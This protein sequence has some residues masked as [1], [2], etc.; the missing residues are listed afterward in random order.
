M[1]K[2]PAAKADKDEK[3]GEELTE[4]R[5]KQLEQETQEKTEQLNACI[6]VAIQM[7]NKQSFAM[8]KCK[9]DLEK[10]PLDGF[11][12]KAKK[13]ETQ[14]GEL[15]ET[16]GKLNTVDGGTQEYQLGA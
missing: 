6:K 9:V 3:K 2:R 1:M 14:M 8:S 15:K 10:A 7:V 11:K 4:D 13:R 16:I 5:V 12:A